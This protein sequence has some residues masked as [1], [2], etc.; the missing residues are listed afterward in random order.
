MWRIKTLTEQYG[1][2][3]LGWYPVITD[4][5]IE[6]TD[7][8][9]VAAFVDINLFVKF[10]DE[11]SQPIPGTGG[12]MYISKEKGGFYVND[13]C[14][15]MA[16]TDAISVACKLQGFGADVYWSQDKSKYSKTEDETQNENKLISYEQ[17]KEIS[18]ICISNFGKE[19]AKYYLKKLTGYEST[20]EIPLSE[21]KAVKKMIESLEVEE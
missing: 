13:E 1:P 2:C 16:Y 3:G 15:K 6:K 21:F 10:G 7:T 19:R 12:S 14:F 5:W 9:E 17:A 18:N 20:K 11:W 4:K 8:G